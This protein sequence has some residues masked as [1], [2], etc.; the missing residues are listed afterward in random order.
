MNLAG[1]R[2]EAHA[3]LRI[4]IGVHA[5]PHAAPSFLLHRAVGPSWPPPSRQS[6][7]AVALQRA[8][9]AFGSLFNQLLGRS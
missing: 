9:C 2:D 8:P 6:S 5:D 4:R 3:V 7:A 1:S